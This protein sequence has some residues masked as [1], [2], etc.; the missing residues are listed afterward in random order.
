MAA[1][2]A[3]LKFSLEPHDNERL[4]NLCGQF[5]EHMR[6]VENRLGVE[7]SHRGNEFYVSGTKTAAD[8]ASAVLEKLYALTGQKIVDMEDLHLNMQESE[9]AEIARRDAIADVVV[10]TRRAMVKA[11]GE[12]QRGYIKSIQSNDV[13]FG[14][15]PAGTG[16]TYLA[17][18]CAVEAL[19]A[20]RVRRLCFAG[21]P[22]SAKK[23]W[24]P[25]RSG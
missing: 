3:T 18:A 14:I 15:G 5:D 7:I 1:N 11:R 20:D 19:E 2:A 24:R 16:K 25:T 22:K 10:R 8:A 4:A 9:V 13:S 23:R 12:N 6:F 17:V 21:I